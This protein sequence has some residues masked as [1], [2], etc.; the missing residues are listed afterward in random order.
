MKTVIVN[1]TTQV[2]MMPAGTKPPHHF[3]VGLALQEQDKP[4]TDLACTFN[5]VEGGQMAGYVTVCAEDGTELAPPLTFIVDVPADVAVPV[6]VTV[7]GT[8][9]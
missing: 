4:L 2:T 6:P 1:W 8:V 3:K 7:N 9:Q 5:N